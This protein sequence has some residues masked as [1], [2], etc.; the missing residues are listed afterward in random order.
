MNARDMGEIRIELDSITEK[1][2]IALSNRQRLPRNEGMY[3]P[4]KVPEFYSSWLD[5]LCEAGDNPETYGGARSYDQVILKTIERRF[6]C[7]EEIAQAKYDNGPASFVEVR[8]NDD[9]I[10]KLLRKPDR[11]TEVIAEAEVLARQYGV[12]EELVGSIFRYLID[13]NVAREI[14]YVKRLIKKNS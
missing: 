14:N 13:E 6:I 5:Q 12:D 9:A 8:N 3:S 11:E 1:L 7:G 2:I 4:S 10:E